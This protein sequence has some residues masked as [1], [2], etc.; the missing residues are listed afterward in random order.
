[1]PSSLCAMSSMRQAPR[2]S[3]IS[4]SFPALLLA[5][6]MLRTQ[7]LALRDQ[8]FADALLREREQRVEFVAAE[9]VAFG[10]TLQLDEAAAVVHHDVHVGVAGGILGIVQVEHGRA[11][12]DAD[13]H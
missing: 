2:I 8:Q 1:M 9:R 10:G 6:T 11:A 12:I 3:R 7:R 13:G 4:P 5:S